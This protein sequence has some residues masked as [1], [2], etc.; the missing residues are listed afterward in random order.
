MLQRRRA[1]T[2]EQESSISRL[3][4]C[5]ATRSACRHAFPREAWNMRIPSTERYQA[6]FLK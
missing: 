5:L 3:P 1:Q 6:P 2:G 4:D